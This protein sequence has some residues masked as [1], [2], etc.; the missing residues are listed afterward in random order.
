M[1]GI[2]YTIAAILLI[3]W[4]IGWLVV[5]VAFWGIHLLIVAAVIVVLLS[6]LGGRRSMI[7]SSR[8]NR[9]SSS[10]GMGGKRTRRPSQ[11]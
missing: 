6:L 1:V 9:Y 10:G 7:C 4:L 11:V 8:W 5:H 2:L 3:A